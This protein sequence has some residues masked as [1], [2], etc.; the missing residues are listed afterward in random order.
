MGYESVDGFITPLAGFIFFAVITAFIVVSF[1]LDYHWRR[2]STNYASLMHMRVAYISISGILIL[3]MSV[4][5][6][7]LFPSV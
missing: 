1:I 6:I 5:L 7:F 3:I 2:Y 4:A